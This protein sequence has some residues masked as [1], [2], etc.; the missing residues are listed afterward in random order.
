MQQCA[1][2]HRNNPHVVSLGELDQCY[3]QSPANPAVST[4]GA[5]LDRRG[6]ESA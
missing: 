4:Y 6:R 1:N 2:W 5:R 3:A